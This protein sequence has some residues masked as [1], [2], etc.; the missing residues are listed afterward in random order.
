MRAVYSD[1]HRQHDP[2]FALVRGTMR[3]SAEQPERADRLLAAVRR[4]GR[5]VNDPEP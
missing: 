3:P 1:A 2:A 4:L 5:P